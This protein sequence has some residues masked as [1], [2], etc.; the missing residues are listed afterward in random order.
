MPPPL[1]SFPNSTAV[2]PPPKRA[3]PQA[4][5]F[6]AILFVP[7]RAPFEPFDTRKKL[8]NIKLLINKI[9]SIELTKVF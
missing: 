8:N 9:E 7:R 4:Q 6:K 1:L 2:Q 3:T 5:L